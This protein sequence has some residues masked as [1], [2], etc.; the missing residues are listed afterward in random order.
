MI[1]KK[2]DLDHFGKFSGE[3][4]ELS[5]G[6]NVISGDIESG[7]STVYSFIECMMFGAEKVRGRG[8]GKDMYSKYLPW[9]GAGTYNGR[10]TFY[11][12]DINY[13]LVR[14]FNVKNQT[15]QLI[16]EDTGSQTDIADISE[17]LP[18]MNL[19]NYRN[20]I[21]TSGKQ[22]MPD[23]KFPADMQ[24]YMANMAMGANDAID[25]GGVLN[26]LKKE[27]KNIKS[28]ISDQELDDKKARLQTIRSQ[29]KE[30]EVLN[31]EQGE[32]E[33]QMEKIRREINALTASAARQQKEDQ[34]DRM[35][36][37]SLI[38]Q[39]NDITAA[40][41]DKKRQL[42]ELEESRGESDEQ[43]AELI[44]SFE[45]RQKNL[46]RLK[47]DRNRLKGEIES[48][49]IK[50]L[51][52][53]L[54]FIALAM[55]VY[56][57][58]NAIGLSS[59]QRLI[60]SLILIVA[61]V[62][63]GAVLLVITSHK[64]NKLDALMADQASLEEKQQTFLARYD[65]RSIEQLKVLGA[66]RGKTADIQRTKKELAVLKKRYEEIQKPLEP[67]IEKYGES[68]STDSSA[69]ENERIQAD[70]LKLRLEELK[71]EYDKAEWQLEQLMQ[72]ESEGNTISEEIAQMEEDREKKM[73]DLKAIEICEEVIRD[74]T[75]Q[76]HGS[77]GMQLNDYISE[78]LGTITD[79]QHR[80]LLIDDK[81]DV[82]VDDV[83]LMAVGQ[84]GSTLQGYA[85]ELVEVAVQVV[86]RQGS[87][88]QVFHQLIVAVLAVDVGLAVVDNLHHHLEVEVL[89][90]AQ[91]GLLDD[92][93]G[94]VDL[95]HHLAL[96]ALHQEHL[97]LAGVVAQALDG[98]VHPALQH[99]V[100]LLGV[101]A[102]GLGDSWPDGLVA[103]TC[104]RLCFAHADGGRHVATA[105]GP[106]HLP[107]SHRHVV[108]RLFVVFYFVRTVLS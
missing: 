2:L 53:I 73:N 31:K 45:N 39:N 34:A 95:Q 97:C 27:I 65:V 74:I 18:G 10:M 62:L 104:R 66:G 29:T 67:Y 61:A 60:C 86:L 106:G 52:L 13:R 12:N 68:I 59:S 87:A 79:G 92:E 42:K 30:I 50:H 85:A 76:I 75:K 16:N 1:I 105:V 63:A 89:H 24:S 80:R 8:S 25:V 40:Y 81:F 22:T 26:H 28:R 94:I 5:P 108:H 19:A 14:D 107:G 44:A 32:V 99:E 6:M 88:P 37:A 55:I 78:L 36:A 71:K 20:S 41:R 69:G 90:D 56:L 38:Q 23:S 102:A 11:S 15:A 58:G 46:D 49:H 64:R 33:E 43:L 9:D 84:C 96:V 4:I 91:Q 51:V 17:I 98:L 77:F 83:V 54:P 70:E 82:L 103:S 3:E 47:A 101:F 48:S 93:V 57:F 100:G 72:L 35:R 21:S 7:K